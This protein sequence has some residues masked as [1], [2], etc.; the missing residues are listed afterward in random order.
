MFV[1]EVFSGWGS[2]FQLIGILLIFL[3][4]LVI[5][6]FTTRWIAGYQQGMMKNR[7]VQI[8][9]TFRV[10]NNK[11]IQIIQIGQKYLV[12]SVCKDTINVLTELTEN[13]LTWKPSEEEFQGVK[14]NE[15]FQDVLNRLKDKIPRK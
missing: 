6:Y 1:M 15:T 10:T 3:F 7:N 14:M 8:V 13:E 4:V 12:I 5:T 11:F 9:E 2:F